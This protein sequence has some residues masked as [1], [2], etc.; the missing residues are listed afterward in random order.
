MSA[1]EATDD[2]RRAEAL[3]RLGLLGTG[4]EERFDR[5]TRLASQEFGLD[6]ALVNLVGEDSLWAKSQPVGVQFGTTPFGVAF[7]EH[8][9][10]GTGLLEIP[11][12]A[13]D[14]RW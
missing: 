8:T 10:R 7:C 2:A 12:A 4:A 1:A 6:L 3:D 14:P 5:I 11:D 13:A 9:V